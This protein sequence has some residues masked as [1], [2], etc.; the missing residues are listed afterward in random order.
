MVLQGFRYFWFLRSFRNKLGESSAL[1]PEFGLPVFTFPREQ[2]ISAATMTAWQRR[3]Q[4]QQ[5]H[6]TEV[7]T[8]KAVQPIA[9]HHKLN[10][11][12]EH[13]AF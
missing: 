2:S 6:A 3:N 13:T 10:K 4:P 7:T 5:Q 9:Q 12:S 8:G 1:L 11:I